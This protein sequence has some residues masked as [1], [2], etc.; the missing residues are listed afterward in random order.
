MNLEK[1]CSEVKDTVKKTGK[2][3]RRKRKNNSQLTIEKKGEHD[4]VTHLDKLSEKK[5]VEKLKRIF[6]SAGFITEENTIQPSA[7]KY[8]W[9]IDPIDGTTNFIHDVSPY[10]ISVAL[11][12][13]DKIILGVVYE[14]TLDELFYTWNN[15]PS[16]LNGKEIH[17]SSSRNFSKA[18]VAT[19]FPYTRTKRIK[20]ILRTMEYFL[21]HCQ[22]IRR[23][24]SAATDLC[25]VACGRF[26]IYYEG[27]LNI[28]DVAAGIILVKNAGG[29]VTDFNGKEN[30]KRDIVATN[31]FLL[32][33]TLKGIKMI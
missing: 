1:M 26:D 18:L 24:G 14:I 31:K 27:Y 29:V 33:H 28:W 3:I 20:N 16:Y 5:L 22:D 8:N 23:F 15:A 19:G 30:Y 9:I 32:E 6:P 10:A 21:I 7:Q 25:Y 2:S 17:V 13:E 11:A 4:Y 12:E